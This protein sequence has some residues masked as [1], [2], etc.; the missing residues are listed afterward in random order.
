MSSPRYS[1]SICGLYKKGFFQDQKIL[2]QEYL[3]SSYQSQIS[4]F[5]DRKYQEDDLLPKCV[6]SASS[7]Q[8]LHCSY[9]QISSE[10]PE[11]VLRKVLL[12][13]QPE[14]Y[15]KAQAFITVQGLQPVSVAQLITSTV[16][17]G[18]LA[19]SQDRETGNKVEFCFFRF[20]FFLN[21]F[22]ILCFCLRYCIIG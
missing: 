12:S 11:A 6:L 20:F 14:R 3:K 2:K 5:A 18:L 10:E 16:L 21:I 8:E 7:L 17:D 1:I 19:A 13:Q 22:K 9:S 15:K 4:K